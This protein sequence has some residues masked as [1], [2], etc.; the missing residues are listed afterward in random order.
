MNTITIEESALIEAVTARIAEGHY[1][2]LH[3]DRIECAEYNKLGALECAKL[4]DLRVFNEGFEIRAVRSTLGKEFQ[5]RDS[6]DHSKL[7][8]SEQRETVRFEEHYLDIDKKKTE[9]SRNKADTRFIYAATG[10]GSYCLPWKDVKRLKVETLFE[11][12]EETGAYRPFDFRI[13]KFA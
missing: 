7:F 8:D 10:G 2:A 3:T 11:E 12:D 4:L 13:V 5:I 1:L 9:E 6:K